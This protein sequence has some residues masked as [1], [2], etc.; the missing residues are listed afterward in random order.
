MAKRSLLGATAAAALVAGLAWAT[1]GSGSSTTVFVR[2]TLH[3]RVKIQTHPRESNDVFTQRIT[4]VPGGFSGWHSHPGPALVGVLSGEVA[5]YE[6]GSKDCTPRI[7]KAGEAFTE[8]AGHAHNVLSVGTEDY[9][10]YATFV[11]PT[12]APNR[13]DE[14]KPEACAF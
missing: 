14:A 1:P 8:E 7:V 12:G 6:A 13:T 11:L 2:S 3:E 4:I 5:I 10:A 9:V